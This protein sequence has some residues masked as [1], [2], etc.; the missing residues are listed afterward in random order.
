MSRGMKERILKG[1]AKLFYKHGYSGVRVDDI[2]EFIGI[3]KKTIYNH[4]PNKLAL[5]QAVIEINVLGICNRLDEITSD[6]K[7]ELNSIDKILR[8]ML[9]GFNE[10][11]ASSWIFTVDKKNKQAQ[12]LIED[13]IELVRG[14]II[15]MSGEYLD[16]GIEEGMIH[17]DVS[18]DIFPYIVTII[19]EGIFRLNRFPEIEAKG[20]E[21]FKEAMKIIYEGI[22]TSE[23][24]ESFTSRWK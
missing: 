16:K 15:E 19:V 18:K 6:E 17:S 2:A 20:D 10:I 1:A 3:T 22:L 9:F 8:L 24:K 13:A 21:L 12:D 7:G 4:F 23:G 14:K 11:S 5:I